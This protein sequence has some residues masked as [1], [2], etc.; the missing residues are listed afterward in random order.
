[1]GRIA[2]FTAVDQYPTG[3]LQGSVADADRIRSLLAHHEGDAANFDCRLISNA[4]VTRSNLRHQIQQLFANRD[5]ELTLF[6]FAGHGLLTGPQP[7]QQ[8]VL[9]TIDSVP[10]DEGVPMDW[11][12]GQANA[13]QAKERI[14]ILDCCHAG[15]IDQLLAPNSSIALAEGVSVLAATR[16]GDAAEEAS[17]K[18]IFSDHIHAA[19]DGGAADV[20]GFITTA[21]LFAYVDEVMTPWNKRPLYKA[22]VA[23]L[24]RLRRAR[25]AVADDDLRRMAILFPSPDHEYP[26]TPEYERTHASSKPEL[27]EILDL[28][29]KLRAARLVEPIGTPH[30]YFAAMQSKS[31]R[32]LPLGKAYWQQVRN[33]RI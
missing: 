23:G 25:H 17:G 33:N 10:G 18:G 13:S 30:M 15:A 19:L 4:Q 1:M 21:G 3:P 12:L 24:S 32:L 9:K 14:I 22:N 5:A 20:R 2:L 27:M 29:Q 28:L 31:C 8:A 7:H 11:L 16:S 26:L 6:F